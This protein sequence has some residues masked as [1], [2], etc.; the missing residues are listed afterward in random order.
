MP[1]IKKIKPNGEYKSG[2]YE[3][4]NPEKYIGDIHNIIYRSSWE[5]RFCTYCDTNDSIVKWSSEPIAIEYYNPLDKKEHK[6]NVDFYIKVV[7][8][9]GDV[10]EWIIEI[11][12]ENQTKKPIY[13]GKMT[14]AKL[15][16]YNRNMQIWITNQAKFK[17]AKIW[18]EKRGY[19]FGVIDENFLFKSK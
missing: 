10:Q 3:P 12:P 13:E 5:Y 1:D 18:A 19:K 17:A 8:E 14:V 6:Y 7:K 4:R 9:S 11:K 15:K 16:S 2:K